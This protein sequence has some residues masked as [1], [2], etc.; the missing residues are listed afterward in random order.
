M[1]KRKAAQQTAAVAAAP[2]APDYSKMTVAELKAELTKQKL[3]TAGKKAELVDRLTTASSGASA[4]S[5]SEPPAKKAKKDTKKAK[6]E[7]EPEPESAFS[8]AVATLKSVPDGAAAKKKKTRTP[9]VDS[10]VPGASRYVVEQDYDCMLN[11]T[12]IGHNNNKYYVIQL[13]KATG[14][15]TV[16]S[17][18]TRWGRV[19]SRSIECDVD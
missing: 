19:V 14:F 1:P 4:S 7:P 15:G 17:V 11:Q 18:W 6:A 10:H 5:S 12:N 8:K 2:A 9:K 16:Y 3:S 13:L